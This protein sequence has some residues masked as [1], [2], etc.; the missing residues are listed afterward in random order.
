MA[1]RSP[2]VNMGFIVQRGDEARVEGRDFSLIQSRGIPHGARFLSIV[3]LGARKSR[4]LHQCFLNRAATLLHMNFIKR[5]LY[6]C[7]DI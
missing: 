7:V 1:A 5:T 4:G 2:D 3:N 6:L